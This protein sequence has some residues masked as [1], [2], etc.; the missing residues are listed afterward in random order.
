MHSDRHLWCAAV[1][2]NFRE[3]T[4][5]K[6]TVQV[7]HFLVGN[8]ICYKECSFFVYILKELESDTNLH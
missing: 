4:Q 1:R 3:R 2:H 7:S 8:V 5:S 6:V